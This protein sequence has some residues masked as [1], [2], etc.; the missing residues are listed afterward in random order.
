MPTPSGQAY[1]CNSGGLV[2]TETNDRHRLQTFIPWLEAKL[3]VDRRF[4]VVITV[5]F[6]LVGY[7][8][9][10]TLLSR[11]SRPPVNLEEK[12]LPPVEGG[13][14]PVLPRPAP[15]Q[16]EVTAKP[17]LPPEIKSPAPALELKPAPVP[18]RSE[19]TEEQN[20]LIWKRTFPEAA[21]KLK[22]GDACY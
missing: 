3:P 10:V 13:A 4:Y 9:G 19:F 11:I 21:A 16:S 18:D 14:N 6:G 5:L 20:C 8:S 17:A 12:P 7:A 15:V 1:R 2:M 22:P